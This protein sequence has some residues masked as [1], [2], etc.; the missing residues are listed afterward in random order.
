M[1][2]IPVALF[3]S[4]HKY[5]DKKSPTILS[6]GSHIKIVENFFSTC[7][8]NVCGRPFLICGRP[9]LFESTAPHPLFHFHMG[10]VDSFFPVWIV[11]VLLKR[12]PV[13]TF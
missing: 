7:L 12:H 10:L 8:I 4:R 13:L 11:V 2:L 3:N 1:N 9:L 5:C 6:V